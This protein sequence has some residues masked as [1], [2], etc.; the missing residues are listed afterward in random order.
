MR[1]LP[2]GRAIAWDTDRTVTICIWPTRRLVIGQT[3]KSPKIFIA[4][5]FDPKRLTIRGGNRSAIGISSSLSQT[6]SIL[7][8][9]IRQMR[10]LGL[11]FATE[12][13]P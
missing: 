13:R 4:S 5:G 11:P 8:E 1:Y 3:L 12:S 10:K 2:D 6:P 7:D 9:P